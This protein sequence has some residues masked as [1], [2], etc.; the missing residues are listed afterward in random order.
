MPDEI[1]E[2]QPDTNPNEDYIETIKKLKENTVS[3][4]EYDKLRAQNKQL[5]DSL[6]NGEDIEQPSEEVSSIE[7]IRKELFNPDKELS[8]LEYASKALELRDRVLE[9]KGI[10]IFVAKNS[11]YPNE[12]AASAE[13]VASVLQQCIDRA[14][15]DS[16]I[17]TAELQRRTND[18]LIPRRR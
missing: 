4:E 14:E 17:F 12:A 9:E 2:N 6:V 7:D 8:N 11:Q 15:G 3:K 13:R 5:L 1:L 18:I 16:S 10:D